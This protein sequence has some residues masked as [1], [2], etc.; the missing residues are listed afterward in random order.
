MYFVLLIALVLTM[1][2][3]TTLGAKPIIQNAQAAASGNIALLKSYTNF[4]SSWTEIVP[5]TLGGSPALLFYS[6]ADHTGEF[7]RVS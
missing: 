3:G 2:T 4:R 7:Y 1:G 6:Q 5:L